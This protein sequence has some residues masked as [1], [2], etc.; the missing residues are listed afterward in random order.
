VNKI[1]PLTITRKKQ[2]GKKITMLTAHDY[3]MARLLDETGIDIILVGDSLGNLVSGYKTTLP[4][5]LQEILYHSRAV[6]H[7]VERALVISDMPFLSYHISME[8]AKR[9]AGI[10]IKEGGAQGVKI[11]ANTSLIPIMKSIIDIGIPVMGHLGFTPQFLYQLGGYRIQG[12][13][14]ESSEMLM[15]LA[16][17]METIGCFSI[18]LELVPAQLSEQISKSI[19]IP[20]IGIGAGPHCDGQVLVTHDLLGMTENFKPKFLKQYAKLNNTIKKAVRSFKK[21]VEDMVYPGKEH[22]FSL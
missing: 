5:T 1:H 14:R 16:K 20:T 6:S 4:V 10:L 8:E 9:N 3:L 13:T 11:E 19:S 21:E 15:K 2:E 7:G 17:D 22:S 18:V 12:K